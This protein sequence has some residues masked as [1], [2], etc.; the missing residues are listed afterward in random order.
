[1]CMGAPLLAMDDGL[2]PSPI[3][4]AA[5][6]EPNLT[7]AANP[8]PPPLPIPPDKPTPPSLVDK[9]LDILSPKNTARPDNLAPQKLPQKLPEKIPQ[10]LLEAEPVPAKKSA[11]PSS[12]IEISPN[13]VPIYSFDKPDSD[14]ESP[15]V[16]PFFSTAPINEVHKGTQTIIIMLHDQTREAARA[17]AY[18]RSAQEEATARH[19]EW[20]AD[21]S[22]IFVPQF[23][24]NEDIASHAQNWQDGGAALLR[25]AGNNWM[26]GGDSISAEQKGIWQA[27]SGAKV[28]MSSFT[29]MDFM[30]LLLARPKL[31]PDL[32]KV[33]IAGTAGGADFVQRYAALGIAP[34]V[35]GDEGIEVRFVPAQTRS[36][37]YLDNQRLVEK[38]DDPLTAKIESD[39]F[40]PTRPE[41]CK[42]M[43]TYP[44][45]LDELLPYGRKNAVNET[46][47]NYSAKRMIYLAGA[48]ATLPIQETTPDSCALLAQG[49]SV[50]R[51]SEIFF[52]S[53]KRIYGD[54]MDRMQKLYLVQ[55]VNEDGLSLWR[56]PCGTSALFG[57]GACNP[58]D[59][60]GKEMQI[61]R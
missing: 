32:Q 18:A 61:I 51:R 20:N 17:F 24:S 35:L 45:G 6:P 44:F 52:A 23:L 27:K 2:P 42:P 39:A 30:L 5:P 37:M 54:D 38:R 56:S 15:P 25:W 47:L 36:F 16:L 21:R 11:T 33:V 49:N 28:N 3:F 57:D 7:P 60:G 59:V 13:F 46:R 19:P 53:L 58:S 26:L 10:T 40:A 12:G 31:F 41:A 55:G 34:S 14:E 22:F 50:R 9:L 4:Q 8:A 29:V 48:G 43:N 1:M